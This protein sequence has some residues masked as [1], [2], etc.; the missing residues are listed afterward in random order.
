[1]TLA[2]FVASLAYKPGWRFKLAGP[3]GRWLCVY[4]STADSLHPDRGRLTQHQFEFP[5]PLPDHRELCRWAR[6][7]LLQIEWH[8]ACEFL[9]VD[10]HRPFFPHHQ[11]EGSPYE[12]I[13]RWPA[14]SE[15]ERHVAP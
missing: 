10:G 3:G 9:A 14:S 11:D 1:M 13:A 5:D 2:G 6:D 12:P 7:R 15:G 4:A 8:E